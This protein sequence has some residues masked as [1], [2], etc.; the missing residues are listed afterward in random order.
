MKNQ[1][2][3]PWK[4]K[5]RLSFHTQAEMSG[6]REATRGRHPGRQRWRERKEQVP[7]TEIHR[8]A[9]SPGT[10]TFCQLQMSSYSPITVLVNLPRHTFSSDSLDALLSPCDRRERIFIPVPCT[11]FCQQVLQDQ[12]LWGF[13]HFLSTLLLSHHIPGLTSAITMGLECFIN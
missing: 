5:L 2:A 12:S 4:T 1:V 10:T 6:E 9:H 8:D 7:W 11:T 3:E 13:S